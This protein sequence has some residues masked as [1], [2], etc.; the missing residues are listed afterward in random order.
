MLTLISD[1][2]DV[3]SS[4]LINGDIIVFQIAEEQVK[5]EETKTEENQDSQNTQEIQVGGEEKKQLNAPEYFN[6]LAYSVDVI[7]RKLEAPKDDVCTIKLDLRSS[8]QQIAIDFAKKIGYDKPE[9]L[10][11]TRYS[12]YMEGPQSSPLDPKYNEDLKSMLTMYN[13]V[14]PILY[15]ETLPFSLKE[16]QKM[17]LLD[18]I[19]QDGSTKTLFEGIHY[20]NKEKSSL[21]LFKE[22]MISKYFSEMDPKPNLR[23]MQLNG[24]QIFSVISKEEYTFSPSRNKFL[25]ECCSK[26]ES[27]MQQGDLL[28]PVQ[29]IESN[30]YIFGNPFMFVAKKDEKLES[31]KKRIQEKLGVEESE[32]K[33]WKFMT[34]DWK[35]PTKAIEDDF[36]VTDEKRFEDPKLY[37]YLA[38]RHNDLHKKTSS[39]YKEEGIVI[40]KNPSNITLN[41]EKKN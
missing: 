9:N 27:E 40:K 19:V 28:I 25:V 5:K 37:I 41:N 1:E 10:R 6:W 36:V 20:L 21:P 26:E 30:N 23:V 34:Q 7:F 17:I 4:K 32:F 31:I 29:H 18:I 2:N 12:F 24:S 22:E 33:K 11:F 35:G 39:L 16:L 3:E 15:Y 14:V 8:Y 13:N 38:M